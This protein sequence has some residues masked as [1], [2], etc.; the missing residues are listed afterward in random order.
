VRDS[1]RAYAL[2][3]IARSVATGVG[4]AC[5]VAVLHVVTLGREPV[6]VLPLSVVLS[7]VTLLLT[8]FLRERGTV[9]QSGGLVA[10]AI[11]ASAAW[12]MSLAARSPDALAVLTRVLGFGILGEAYLWRALPIARGQHRWREVRNDALLG[13]GCVVIA[14]LAPGP[15]DRDVLPVLGLMVAF[16]GAVA[17]SLARSTEELALSAGQIRGRAAPGAATGT[18]FALGALALV[19]GFALPVAQASLLG[20]ARA[21]GP[22]LGDLL[23]TILLPL[24]Y[25]AA[26]LIVLARWIRELLQPTGIQIQIPRSPF[27]PGDEQARLREMEQT[28]PYIFGAL[29]ILVGLVALAFAVALVARMIQERRSVLPEGAALERSPVDGIGLRATL[30]ALFPH[31]AARPRPPAEDG[32]AATALRRVYWALLDLSE[33]SGPGRRAAAETPAEHEDRLLRAGSRWRDAS[34]IV[35]A[36]EDLRYGELDPDPATVERAR[37]ALQHLEASA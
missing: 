35:R 5:V 10:V 3:L 21:V 6:A 26:Y 37:A 13:L 28:R 15:L 19:I 20:L 23:F 7:G 9:R 1:G 14:S 11:V 29:E 12:G 34:E 16:A 25:L 18:A 31:R 4:F 8:S 17:L 2:I 36:F 33:R 27:D 32:T 22:L 24:G 30:R